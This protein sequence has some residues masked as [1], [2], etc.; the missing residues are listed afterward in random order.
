[1]N[2]SSG[3]QQLLTKQTSHTRRFEALSYPFLRYTLFT[4]R[5]YLFSLFSQCLLLLFSKCCNE[6]YVLIC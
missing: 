2:E 5:F 1:M 3:E 4:A 6:A